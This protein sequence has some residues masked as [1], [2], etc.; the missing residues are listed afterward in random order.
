MPS[1]QSALGIA[2][3]LWYCLAV[4]CCWGSSSWALCLL[5]GTSQSAVDPLTLKTP[6]AGLSWCQ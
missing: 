4:A 2:N 1:C 3:Q 6:E 5:M